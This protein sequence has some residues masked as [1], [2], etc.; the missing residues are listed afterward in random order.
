LHRTKVPFVRYGVASPG[1]VRHDPPV[2]GGLSQ[3]ARRRRLGRYGVDAPAVPAALGGSGLVLLVVGIVV[4]A[5]AGADSAV[6]V[7]LVVWA[8]VAGVF[9]VGSAA[10]YL[11]TTLRGKFAVWADILDRLGLRGGEHVLD[12]GCG[13]GAV[14]LLVAQRLTGG[15][16]VGVDLWRS[17]DQSGTPRR[18]PGRTRGPRASPT[19]WSCGRAT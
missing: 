10:I 6:G 17:V 13:R 12:M 14:L 15:R 5:T 18:P 3:E 1:A 4:L 16:A 8:L 11:H 9:L 2:T 7:V 19:A